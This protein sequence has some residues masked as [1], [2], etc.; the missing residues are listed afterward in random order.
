MHTQRKSANIIST[1]GLSPVRAEPRAVPAMAV[2]LM[3]VSFT[4][5][6]PNSFRSP[7]VTPKMP[8]KTPMSSPARK[9][10]SSLLSSSRRASLRASAKVISLISLPPGRGYG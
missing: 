6:G 5:L 7:A 1:T 2:S 10:F 9:T 8:P 4:R 3:G